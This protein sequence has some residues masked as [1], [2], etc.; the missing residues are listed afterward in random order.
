MLYRRICAAL[1]ASIAACANL[2]AFDECCYSDT[3]YSF[4]VAVS[5]LYWEPFEDGLGF[6][7]P[8]LDMS[9][10]PKSQ[11][12]THLKS[13][14]FD[15]DLG[16]RVEAGLRSCSSWGMRFAWTGFNP[17]ATSHV[18]S[19][20]GKRDVVPTLV[21]VFSNMMGSSNNNGPF[22]NCS[23]AKSHWHLRFNTFTLDLDYLWK[24]HPCVV[25]R[26]YVGVIG[27]A[28]RQS[29]TVDYTN[30]LVDDS[31]LFNAQEKRKNHFTG[32]GPRLGASVNWMVYDNISV[33]AD[34]FSAYLVGRFINKVDVTA[35]PA[36]AVAFTNFKSHYTR[37]RP[38]AG[39]SLGLGYAIPCECMAFSL[40][41]AYEWQ[42]WWRQLHGINNLL[43][44]AIN[45]EGSWEDL[46]V[47]GLVVRGEIAF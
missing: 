26:P 28:I 10:V 40:S 27:A 24:C 20:D 18:S 29:Q 15:W 21:S 9:T 46:T 38:M 2:A 39:G 14:N 23:D 34:A 17:D 3:D 31:P 5:L 44:D 7:I 43:Y 13:H 41:V 37:A 22:L 32:V 12:T 4:D 11:L 25:V 8:G 30:L 16:V 47:Q 35:P 42:Y 19:P 6:G 45:G 33:I 1:F 36:E